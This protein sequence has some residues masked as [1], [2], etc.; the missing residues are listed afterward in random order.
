ML[1]RIG[2]AQAL[3]HSP[4][5]LILDEPMSGLDPDGRY[6]VTQIIQEVAASGATIFFSSHLLTDVER[7]CDRLVIIDHGKIIYEGLQKTF[8]ATGRSGFEITYTPAASA[9][10][11]V[12]NCSDLHEV[13]QFLAQLEKQKGRLVEV[14]Q[15][16]V[17]LEEAFNDIK[18]QHAYF[19][20]VQ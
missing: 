4:K 18:K 8:V 2:L 10:A 20:D 6:Q 17:S 16:R 15:P 5:F 12:Q 14:R 1:Q 19:R 13:A 11:A 9:T 7:L 3:I